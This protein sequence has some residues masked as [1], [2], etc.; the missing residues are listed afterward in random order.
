MPDTWLRADYQYTEHRA[1]LTLSTEQL[2]HVRGWKALLQQQCPVA[3][4]TALT[5]LLSLV[6]GGRYAGASILALR[7][8]LPRDGWQVLV[9]H[10][11]LARVP[12]G[13][14]AP[15][16]LVEVTTAD[17]HAALDDTEGTSN[18]TD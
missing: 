11:S 17:L 18:A 10:H 12:C 1:V 5:R 13:G 16:L 14:R 15:D 6:E 8:E 2:W 7:Y 3:L 4:A 9:M